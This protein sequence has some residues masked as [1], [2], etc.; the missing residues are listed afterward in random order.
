MGTSDVIEAEGMT[1]SEW[2]VAS[3]TPLWKLLR[4][5]RS[6]GMQAVIMLR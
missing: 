3:I 4:R 6:D 5:G 2:S 1:G